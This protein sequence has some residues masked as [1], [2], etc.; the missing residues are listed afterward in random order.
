MKINQLLPPRLS[1]KKEEMLSK[2]HKI[3]SYRYFRPLLFSLLLLTLSISSWAIKAHAM[4]QQDIQVGLA[5]KILRFH[6]IANSDSEADQSLKL[7]VKDTLVASLRPE[8]KDAEDLKE[9]RSILQDKLPEIATLAEATIQQQGYSYA[10][11]VTLEDCYFPLK[12]Y[13]KYTCFVDETYSIV[14]EDAN[15]KLL[16]LLSDE[17]YETLISNKVPVKIKFKLL[18]E[19]KE[20]F[21]T[22]H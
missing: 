1:H 21:Q 5:E 12:V 17:E 13:G 15:E 10:V 2:I 14:D 19:L 22:W 9:V 20:L 4:S 7:L 11:K 6:V 16:Q 18:E 3:I 8:L